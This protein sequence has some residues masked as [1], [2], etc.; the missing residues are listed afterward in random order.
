MSAS[1]WIGVDFDGTLSIYGGWQGKGVYGPPVLAM[2][3]RVCEWHDSGVTV[4]IVTA[5]AAD[6]EERDLVKRWLRENGLPDLEITDRK[7]FGMIELWDDRAVQV[8][9]NTG[10]RMDGK[11]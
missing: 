4:K 9:Y 10:R 5:R 3:R 2:A 1:G 7:D 8:E 6:P 11:P